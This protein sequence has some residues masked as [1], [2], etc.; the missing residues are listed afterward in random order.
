MRSLSSWSRRNRRSS[1]SVSDD[2]P[3]PPVPV[4]PSTGT[5]CRGVSVDLRQAARLSASVSTRATVGG[6]AGAEP[7]EGRRRDGEVDVALPHHQVDH[8]GQPEPLAVFGRED[9][10]DPALVQQRD[11]LRDDHAPTAAVD[12]HVPGAALAQ[13]LDEVGEVLD[14]ARPGRS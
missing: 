8:P 5:R 11:L 2:L 4:M 10:R 12:L 1:S 14:V 13:Q 7:V 3:E 6:I 9:P